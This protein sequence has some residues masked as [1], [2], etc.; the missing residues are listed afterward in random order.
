MLP[1]GRPRQDCVSLCLEQAL[2]AEGVSGP[3]TLA[4]LSRPCQAAVASAAPSQGACASSLWPPLW[5]L[6][7]LASPTSF[8]FL[9]LTQPNPHQPYSFPSKVQGAGLSQQASVGLQHTCLRFKS[10]DDLSFLVFVFFCF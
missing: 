7:R 10:V 8:P 9:C 1:R 2:R 3:S 4:W 5:A 6:V